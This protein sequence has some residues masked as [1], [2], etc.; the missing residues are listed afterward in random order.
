MAG[1]QLENI[2]IGFNLS[3]Y[4][5]KNLIQLHYPDKDIEELKKHS[6]K[7]KQFITS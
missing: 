4:L 6:N 5:L 2:D 7:Y 1:Y 3:S